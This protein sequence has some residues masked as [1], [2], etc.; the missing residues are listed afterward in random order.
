MPV[1]TRAQSKRNFSQI[2][3]EKAPKRA[4]LQG[5]SVDITPS[6]SS[7]GW[8]LLT[9]TGICLLALGLMFVPVAM[10][11]PQRCVGEQCHQVMPSSQMS[12]TPNLST[13]ALTY[14]GMRQCTPAQPRF[15]KNFARYMIK[16]YRLTPDGSAA[17]RLKDPPE[18][19]QRCLEIVEDEQF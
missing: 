13:R 5:R 19:H 2:P 3:D 8:R 15:S 18:L 14:E 10:A 17:C 9:I 7:I 12:Q 11:S 4:K 1:I 6:Q 16:G